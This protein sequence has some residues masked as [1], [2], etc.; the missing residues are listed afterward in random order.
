MINN[1]LNTQQ[2]SDFLEPFWQ[3]QYLNELS[4]ENIFKFSGLLNSIRNLLEN[5]KK[6]VL[7]IPERKMCT[8]KNITSLLL[9]IFN[10][11]IVSK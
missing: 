8:M 9:I 7:V 11:S 6:K 1:I 5:E 10:H 4:G 3:W 2:W